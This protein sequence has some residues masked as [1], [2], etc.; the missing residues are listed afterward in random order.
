MPVVAPSSTRVG[1]AALA[2]LGEGYQIT[3]LNDGSRL[4]ILLTQVWDDALTEVLADHPWN[5]ALARLDLAV[6][7]GVEPAGSEYTQAF[8]KPNDC[9]RWLPWS[10]GHPDYFDGEEEGDYILS[11]DA[12]PIA[13][14]YIKLLED[15]NK[16]T[17][18]MRACLS[19]KLAEKIA[20]AVTGQTTMIDRMAELYA[21]TLSKAKRQDGGATGNRRRQAEYRSNWNGSR[22]RSW[23]GKG[24]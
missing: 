4:G 1:N 18:G 13:F 12:A 16:W 8:L 19:A 7:A 22:N 2:H 3:A 11:N 15:M 9:V 17:P 14:R 10:E 20:K 6:A 24:V 23:S 21:D 5:P